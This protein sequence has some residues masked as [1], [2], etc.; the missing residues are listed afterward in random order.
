VHRAHGFFAIK[1]FIAALSSASSA[2]IRLSLL[3]SASSSLTRFR[4]DASKPLYF[5]FHW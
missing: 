1:Y 4:S 3:F 2:Y 5:D